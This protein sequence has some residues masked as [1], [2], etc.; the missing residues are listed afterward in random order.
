M[1]ALEAKFTS[2]GALG[3]GG[4]IAMVLGALLLINGPPEVRIHLTTALAVVIPFAVITIFL[5]TLVVKARRNKA[6]MSYAG[7][8]D[9]IGEARTALTPTGKV[10]V[11]GEYWDA[12]STSPAEP[13]TQVRVVG[14]DGLKLRV[15]PEAQPRA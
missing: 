11:H 6:V 5:M 4:A 3:I 12:V 15:K 9:E 8:L 14:V 10:F 2:H 13:G 7:M 1:F